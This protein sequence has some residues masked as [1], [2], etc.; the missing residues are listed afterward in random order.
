ML[1]IKKPFITLIILY[2][3][4]MFSSCSAKDDSRPDL[5]IDKPPQESEQSDNI[6]EDWVLDPTGTFSYKSYI[7]RGN[8]RPFFDQNYEYPDNMFIYETETPSTDD[9]RMY[10]YMDTGFGIL[11]QPISLEPNIFMN[12][13]ARIQTNTG[14]YIVDIEFN[15]IEEYKPGYVIFENALIEVT[16]TTRSIDDPIVLT[17]LDAEKYL[18][19]YEIKPENMPGIQT[20]VYG[21]KTIN[22][23]FSDSVDI[24]DNFAID[25]V[26]EYA[27]M[28]HDG[29]AA[30][31][32][33]GKW[34]Y[35]DTEGNVVVDFI[36]TEANDFSCGIGAVSAAQTQ[37]I[38]ST[39]EEIELGYSR[40]ALIDASG[41]LITPFEYLWV[42]RFVNGI[43]YAT[44]DATHMLYI[45]TE[46]Q[47]LF[48]P[49]VISAQMEEFSDGF[50]LIFNAGRYFYDINGKPLL[51]KRFSGARS[52]SDGL[53]A[54]KISGGGRW[55]Y[56]DTQGK[57]VLPFQYIIAY[58]FTMGYAF[59]YDEYNKPSGLIDKQG[60]KYLKTLNLKNISRFNDNGYALGYSIELNTYTFPNPDSPGDNISEER[61]DKVYYM[62]HIE[63]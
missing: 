44:T 21:Y 53:A 56:I 36:Y 55:G 13:L 15:E 29:L 54:V 9:I 49:I 14:S 42:S 63:K 39:G 5:D 58:D 33:N 11:S 2:L 27:G 47:H 7:P 3:I 6:S 62:I 50:A 26:F 32:M 10:G 45:N 60:N 31:K 25:A 35:I 43:A 57:T 61:E 18:V 30:A 24:E 16:W 17:G 40:W 51:N 4:I 1:K 22:D 52:F 37:I 34:G 8:T 41:S 46:G 12:G 23:A 28:F 48:S 38:K 19:P 59:V 20:S